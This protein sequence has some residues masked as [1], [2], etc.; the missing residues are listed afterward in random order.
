M[1]MSKAVL[2][3]A[4][5]VAVLGLCAASLAVALAPLGWPFE[6]F[7]HFRWQ[8]AA[9]TLVVAPVAIA[10]RVP[11]MLAL[12]ALA[13]ALQL[14]PFVWPQSGQPRVGRDCR[15]PELRIATVNLWYRH[16]DATYVLAWLE[17][18]PA[19]VVVLQEV[20]SEWA[21]ALAATAH[22]YPHRALRV[23]EDPYGIGV[24]SRWPLERVEYVDFAQDG[25]PSLVATL[26]VDG[27]R[28]QVIALHTPWP[29]LKRLQLA[30]DRALQRAAERAR[31]SSLP[32]LLAGDFNLT[33]Y[34]P[35]FQRLERDSRMRDAFARRLWRPT[36]QAGFWPLALPIDHV[37]VPDGACVQDAVIGDGVGSDHRPVVVTVRWP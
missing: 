28:V 2:R 24:L 27:R 21:G 32:T 22:L 33:P 6:L 14:T 20:T 13:L 8:L 23:R 37:F 4:V 3:R 34:A 19:D 11:R 1:R 26:D 31:E 15:G 5:G 12:P 7:A 16:R 18:H 25:L 17:A 30:R 9:A 36:W 35:T 10:L 29:I